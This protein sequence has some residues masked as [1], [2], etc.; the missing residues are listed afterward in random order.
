MHFIIY[1]VSLEPITDLP[2]VTED[3]ILR[4]GF[5][6][7]SEHC[8]VRARKS[9]FIPDRSNLISAKGYMI[10]RESK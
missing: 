8:T 10:V 4:P 9:C 3:D 7:I 5:C 2:V 1:H 6:T